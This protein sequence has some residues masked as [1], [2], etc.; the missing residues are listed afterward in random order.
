MNAETIR[1]EAYKAMSLDDRELLRISAA[2]DM[3]EERFNDLNGREADT[4]VVTLSQNVLALEMA[5]RTKLTVAEALE[6][7]QALGVSMDEHAKDGQVVKI[8][9]VGQFAGVV[10]E[11][12][13]GKIVG[14]TKTPA[15]KRIARKTTAKRSGG[16]LG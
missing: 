14:R 6:A 13:G 10:R 16:I 4:S 15:G 9:G 8:R 11:S 5:D 1:L 3:L 7:L 2:N 12:Q